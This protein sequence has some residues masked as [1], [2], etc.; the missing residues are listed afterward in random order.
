MLLAN[1]G[2]RFEVVRAVIRTAG[3]TLVYLLIDL[4]APL[5]LPTGLAVTL[6]G[7]TGAVAAAV[8]IGTVGWNLKESGS[9]A[10]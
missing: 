2:C 6:A 7:D 4:I 1:T 10:R 3:Q 5:A 8:R 9:S